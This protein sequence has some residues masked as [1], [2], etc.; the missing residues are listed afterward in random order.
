MEERRGV[1]SRDAGIADQAA[2]DFRLNDEAAAVDEL[3]TVLQG[4]FAAVRIP[5]RIVGGASGLQD[6]V[7]D[8]LVAVLE[9]ETG[10]LRVPCRPRSL[11][12]SL[13]LIVLSP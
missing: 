8:D 9:N 5:D 12:A 11:N 7:V 4:Q 2:A 3:R 1:V 13:L 10:A 6:G